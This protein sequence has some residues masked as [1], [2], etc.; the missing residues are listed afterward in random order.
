MQ[1]DFDQYLYDLARELKRGM[2]RAR[3]AGYGQQVRAPAATEA[4]AA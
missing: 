4:V 1:V 3:K 2:A